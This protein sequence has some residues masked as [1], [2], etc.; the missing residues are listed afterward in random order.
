MGSLGIKELMAT[1]FLLVLATMCTVFA[2]T[3]IKGEKN[4]IVI[5]PLMFYIFAA[6]PLALVGSGRSDPFMG[7]SGNGLT[8]CARVGYWLCGG[9]TVCGP[10]SA[11]VLYHTAQINGAALGLSLGSGLLLVI[12]GAI[13]AGHKFKGDDGFSG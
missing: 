11:I 5:M 7:G 10:A 12:A 4:P 8:W 3:I 1:S 9:L 13:L 2:C 6:T